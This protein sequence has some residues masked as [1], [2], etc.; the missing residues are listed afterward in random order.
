MRA[1]SDTQTILYSYINIHSHKKNTDSAVFLLRNADIS[2]LDNMHADEYYS[3]GFHPWFITADSLYQLEIFKE[4]V[5]KKSTVYAIGECGLD[6]NISVDFALQQAVFSAQINIANEVKLPLVVHCVRAFYEVISEL[7]KEKNKMPVIYHGYNNS[8][9]IANT[10]IEFNGYL[11]FGK[12]LLQPANNTAEVFKQVPLSRI[13][14][15]ND[16]S[17]LTIQRIYERAAELK[18]MTVTE[19]QETIQTN[20]E[21]INTKWTN[22]G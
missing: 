6:R 5:I 22:L 13:F 3:L 19:L 17:E 16:E 21:N 11:S 20:F 15:E 1:N 12:S 4:A 9:K 18:N 2:E 14:L 10:L 7:K 8:I